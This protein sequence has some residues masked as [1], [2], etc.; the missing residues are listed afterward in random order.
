MRL[1]W[2]TVVAI[3]GSE[4]GSQHLD[5][6]LDDRTRGQAI[7]Y[8]H[9]TGECQVAERVLL[10]TTAVTLGLGTGGVHF[11][12][13]RAG[14]GEGVA[15]E[16]DSGG[17][18]MKLRYTPIQ[19]DVLSVEEQESP[20]HEVMRTAEEIG[21]MP[22]A[23]CGL[24]SHVPLVAAAVKEADPR[25]RIAFVMSDQAALPIALSDLVRASVAAGLLD[26]TITC[27]QAFGG[28][29]EAVNV[30]SGLL[31]A[32]HVCHADVAI[33][34]LGP[35]VVGT[36]TPLGHGGVAQGEA[37]NT[38]ASL[39]G[40]PVVVPRISFADERSRHRGVSHHT[41]TAL[42][43][44][45][46]APAYVAIPVVPGEFSDA[47][48]DALES[49]GVWDRHVR[50]PPLPRTSSSGPSLRGVEVR[51]MG[52]SAAEDPAFFAAAYAAGDVCV[53]LAHGETVTAGSG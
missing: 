1:V 34:A 45:A 21:G 9:L 5:V 13:A 15:H 38:A 27:G 25:L 36:A 35:G 41:V 43:R 14:S 30:H 48:E 47:I 18:I 23:C 31:A 50:V 32:R 17:H 33:V 8:P 49:A 22:V 37:V 39:K 46:L 40:R 19:H 51:T 11:V 29:L 24:H 16:S 26:T 2:A 4:A 53:R 3:K 42:T 28:E 6:A 20:H 52:R 10:N 44:V 7:A 12:V